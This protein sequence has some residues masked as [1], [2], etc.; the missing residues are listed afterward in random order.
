MRPPLSLFARK[1][2]L[3][4]T[5]R[6]IRETCR[7]GVRFA[8]LAICVLHVRYIP[9]AQK[10]P[11]LLESVAIYR[12]PGSDFRLFKASEFSARTGRF[13][14]SPLLHFDTVQKMGVCIFF[15]WKRSVFSE[16]TG[17]IFTFFVSI[18]NAFQGEI[19]SFAR[20]VVEI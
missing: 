8:E 14:V 13:L 12:T 9:E 3:E 11:P 10:Y 17:R 6:R 20:K 4:R 16:R 18:S 7:R 1:S 19:L 5:D 15:A 2:F